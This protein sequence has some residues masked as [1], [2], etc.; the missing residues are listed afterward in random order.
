MKITVD[1]SIFKKRMKKLDEVP[2][3]LMR[4]AFTEL[5]DMIQ[6]QI[7]KHLSKNSEQRIE[8]V[9]RFYG[10]GEVMAKVYEKDGKYKGEIVSSPSPL[11][12]RPPVF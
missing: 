2:N 9:F 6:Q 5:K 1:K 8:N 12:V 3:Q 4:N 10:N 7:R 11:L